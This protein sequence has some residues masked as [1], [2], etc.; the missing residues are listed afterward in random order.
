[1]QKQWRIL[2]KTEPSPIAAAEGTDTEPAVASNEDE[3]E[4]WKD[5]NDQ[6]LGNI[7]LRLTPAIQHRFREETN[8]GS[9][10]TKL[11]KAYGKPGIQSCIWNS[12]PLSK[13]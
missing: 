11:E 13:S 9:L 6:A 4:E 5:T 2:K 10:W 3:V 8:A 1:M 12:R 7:F